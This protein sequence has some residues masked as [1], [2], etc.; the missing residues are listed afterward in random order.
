MPSL[1][2]FHLGSISRLN[3]NCSDI[4]WPGSR[5]VYNEKKR[6]KGMGENRTKEEFKKELEELRLKVRQLEEE[7]LWAGEMGREGEACYF[8]LFSESKDPIY[9]SSREGEILDVNRAA[10]D[11]F[12]YRRE[13]LIGMDISRLYADP[14][15]RQKFQR[16]IEP[17]GSV[18]DYEVRL[19]KKDGI[20]LYCLLSSTVRRSLQ[21]DVI[22]YQ[23]II[24]DITRFREAER[25]LRLSEEKFSTVFRSSPD[26]IA[27][28]TLEE[29]RFIDVNDAFLEITGFSREEVIG[30]TSVELGMWVDAGERAKMVEMLRR[31]GAIKDQETRYRLKS[32]DVRIMLRSA[33]LVEMGGETCIINVTRDITQRKR[34]E[35]EIK[36]LNRELKRRVKELLDANRELDAFSFTVSHDLRTPLVAIGGFARRLRKR[37]LGGLNREATEMLEAIEKSVEKMQ[38]L[39]DALLALSRSGRQQI[40]FSMVDMDGLARSVF[41]EL[42][43]TGPERKILLKAEKLLPVEADESLMRQVFVNLLS[44]AFKFTLPR[45]TAV[46]EVDCKAGDEAVTYSVK[47]NGI[48]F[49][50]IEADKLF[51]V[52][53]RLRSGKDFEGTGI[54]LSIVHRIIARH[55]GS[56]RAEGRPGQGAAFYFTLPVKQNGEKG[57][58]EDVAAERATDAV[59][60]QRR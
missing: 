51:N 9:V 26:W 57:A 24:H 28:S 23:G 31:D 36:K 29:G 42:R 21:G 43:T 1:L 7:R 34:A 58:G 3:E 19:R 6:A 11:L 32:G 52:F 55:G 38:G 10:E 30:H 18:K 60:D 8:E 39:I 40:H 49:D 25:A 44:N 14:A 33:E 59:A 35:E 50:M 17:R 45:E 4:L 37:H 20:G 5:R 54:G 27:I 13:E 53:Q 41:A 47:D 46:I 2:S 48:G 22:G 12:G 56:I 16:D 15:D